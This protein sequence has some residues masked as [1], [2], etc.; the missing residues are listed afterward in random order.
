[1]KILLYLNLLLLPFKMYSQTDTLKTKNQIR[2]K[3]L[4]TS[5]ITYQNN[6][7]GQIGVYKY[8]NLYGSSCIGQFGLKGYKLETEFYFNKELL[9]AP[10]ISC[11]MNFFFVGARLN[12]IDYTNFKYHNFNITPE[13]GFTFYG[14]CNLF[15]GYNIPINKP[16]IDNVGRHKITFVYNF[17]R[18]R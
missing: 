5:G 9:I 12:I 16:Q 18:L 8:R 13:L 15:Y 2:K 3:L 6:L 11:E 17:K 10:K 14:Q 7:G 1:M 4:F